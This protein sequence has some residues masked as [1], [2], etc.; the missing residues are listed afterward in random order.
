MNES[1]RLKVRRALLSVVLVAAL[2]LLLAP[3]ALAVWGSIT[4]AIE[5]GVLNDA[6]GL[7]TSELEVE[8][9]IPVMDLGD[10]PEPSYP[11]LLASNGAHHLAGSGLFLGATV[12]ADDDG[13]RGPT[14]IGDDLASAPA[15]DG[16]LFASPLAAIHGQKFADLNADG[17]RDPEEP[18]L[19]G[20]LIDLFDAS[21]SALLATATT[22]DVELDGVPGIDPVTE[23]GVYL[24]SDLPPDDYVVRERPEETLLQTY[25]TLLGSPEYAVTLRP[26]QVL[27]VAPAEAE[28]TCGPGPHWVDECGTP[29]IDSFFDV[30]FSVA[31][32]RLEGDALSLTGVFS[33]TVFASGETRVIRSEPRESGTGTP[34]YL[35]TIDTQMA[36]MELNGSSPFLGPMRV[37]AG[38]DAG[39]PAPSEGLIQELGDPFMVDSFFDVFFELDTPVGTLHNEVPM[40]MRAS[41]EQVPPYLVD[42]Q[43]QNPVELFGPTGLPTGIFVTDAVHT[44]T[45]GVDFGNAELDFGD[46]PDPTYATVLASNGPR[47]AVGTGLFLGASVDVEPDGQPN[48]DATGDDMDISFPGPHNTPFPPGDEDGLTAATPLVAGQPASFTVV[49]SAPGWLDAWIDFNG[50]GTFDHPAEHLAGGVSALVVPGPNVLSFSVP[51]D[52]AP[53]TS[54]VR[55]RISSAGSLPPTGPAFDGE[56]EDHLVEILIT[57]SI[58]GFKYEDVDGD[59]VYNPA[60]DLPLAGVEFTLTGTDVLGNGVTGATLTDVSGE[61]RFLDLVP[62]NYTVVETVPTGHVATSQTSFSSSVHSGEELVAFPGQAMLPPGDPRFEVLVGVPL[63]FG[64]SVPGSIHGLKFE[65]VD[66]DGVYI[67]AVDLPLAGVEFTLTGTDGQGNVI[68]TTDSTDGSGEFSFTGLLPSVAGAGPATGYTVVE[69]VP[70]GHVATTP[71]AYSTDLLS[72]QE[73]V[74]LPGQAML[75][76]GDPQVEVVVGAPLMFGN[77]VPGSI[78][79]FKYEDV[80]GDGV[81][82]AAVDLPLAGVEFTL[83]GT[84]GQGNA[85]NTTDTTDGS[86][87]FGFAGLLPS[88]AG[89]GPATGYMVVETVPSGFA[90]TTAIA[91]STDLLSRQE[92]VAL[93]GQAMLS[94]GDPRVEV[95][96]GTPLMFGNTV[97]GSIHGFKYKDIGLDGVYNPAVDLPLTGVEFTLT[98]T[99]GQGNVINTTDTTDT[100][101]EFS[102]AGLLPSVSGAG[103]ATGYMVAETVP[104]GSVATTPTAYST[105]LWSRQELVAF[106]GQAAIPPADPRVEVVVGEPLMFGNAST[107]LSVAKVANPVLASPSETVTYTYYVTNTGDVSLT[108]VI[109]LDDPL[110]TVTLGAS[111]LAPD[112]STTGVLTHTVIEGDLPGP[113]VNTVL[114]TGTPPVGAI[115]TA[116]D[117]VSV[118]LTTEMYH[119]WL[120]VVHRS[121]QP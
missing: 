10:A 6:I 37:R 16:L 120:P 36:Y 64:N 66:G 30:F 78:H 54:Y 85:I 112:E 107:K 13:Q 118:T 71:I 28:V 34:G 98:G 47:H 55:L 7:H 74:A 20:F 109:A 93:P 84:D 91:Y 81:Y 46:A 33:E 73:L 11:T 32:I 14:A 4:S 92:L 58:H 12:D 106:A 38:V 62:G 110:G 100:N 59:G 83:T 94:P 48:A 89:T 29:Y 101:G 65:D 86:G 63:M 96:M 51:A 116:T 121:F 23:S 104:A 75:S 15:G 68:N 44:P 103:P 8:M 111:T 22:A 114:V 45:F 60:V 57:G 67:P 72:R 31:T 19:N 70:S 17:R 25:P 76:P 77:T 2:S 80:D 97:P 40:L 115:V 102:F 43:S 108:G 79:G 56:V 18:G 5:E 42:Y 24:L 90:A 21:G 27:G 61:F 26:G 41:I 50:N 1:F 39:V 105:D 49:A 87:E 52:A 117:T 3:S 88:V 99:D 95:V 9:A 69:T 113:M 82:I 35:D 53:G 119:V